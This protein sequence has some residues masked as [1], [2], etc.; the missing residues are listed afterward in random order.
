MV[1]NPGVYTPDQWQV[2]TIGDDVFTA[3][4]NADI[5]HGWDGNDTITESGGTNQIFGDSGNDTIIVTTTISADLFDG[6]SGTGDLINWSAV[7]ETGATF[8]LTAGTA[9]DAAANV[10]VMVNFEYLNGTNNRDIITGTGA[11]NYLDAGAGQDDV[12]GGGGVDALVGGAGQ[13]HRCMAA[14]RATRC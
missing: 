8:D 13:R 11:A 9:T 6:G 1:N 14:P 7:A 10:E 3:T 2:G 12:Y 5:I 4:G